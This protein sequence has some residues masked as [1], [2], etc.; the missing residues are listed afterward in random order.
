M[1]RTRFIKEY[2]KASDQLDKR[3]MKKLINK[4]VELGTL[5]DQKGHS[6]LIITMEEL[7]ELGQQTSKLLRGRCDKIRLVE[8]MADVMICFGYLKEIGGIS[9]NDLY[10][11][12]NVKLDR[13]DKVMN[14]KGVYK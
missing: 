12:M 5:G 8:E 6:N 3:R 2:N 10:K 1:D 4:S 9:T 13:L 14:E 7:S 11:A